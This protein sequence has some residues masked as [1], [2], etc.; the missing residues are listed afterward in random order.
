[1]FLLKKHPMK[2]A[3]RNA[4]AIVAKGRRLTTAERAHLNRWR[5]DEYEDD[6]SWER[7]ATAARVRGLLPPDGIYEGIIREAL[8]MRRYAESVRSGTD[9]DLRE[10]R[11]QHKRHLELAQKADDLAE[12]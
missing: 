9:F 8:H 2:L 12:Y 6:P 11:L 7:L 3:F 5:A 4:L 10:R 1:L